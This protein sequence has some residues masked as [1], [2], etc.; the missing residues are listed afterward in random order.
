MTTIPTATTKEFPIL[1]LRFSIFLRRARLLRP[2]PFSNPKSEI[3]N[4]KSER[5]MTLIA[6]MA[7]MALFAIALLAVAPAVQQEVQREL[8]L[9]SIRRGEEI[10]EAIRR[11][12]IHHNGTKLP[13]SI[14]DLL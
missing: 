11:Y 14:D 5:G 13:D 12:V 3:Q 4:P 2:L 10:A 1:D 6:V 8:E 7:V 9:E